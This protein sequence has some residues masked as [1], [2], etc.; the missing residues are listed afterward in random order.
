MSKK[1]FIILFLFVFSS[2]C[3]ADIIDN[4][5]NTAFLTP[6]LNSSVSANG[7]GTV[8]M[9]KTASAESYINWR[10]TSSYYIKL[11]NYNDR[12]EVTPS[13]SI[14]SGQYSLWIL[15]FDSAKQLL[16]EFQ[17]ASPTSD[18]SIQILKSVTTLAAQNNITNAEW[19]YIRFRL[20]GDTGS[21]FI[22]DKIHVKQGPG[23]WKPTALTQAA[24]KTVF[25]HEMTS[26]RTPGYSGWWDGW[27]YGYK[28]GEDQYYHSPWVLDASGKPDI[29][30]V[31]YPSV[32]CYDMKDP[33]LVE[34]HCQIMKMAGIGGAIFDLGFYSMDMDNVSMIT[35]YLSIMAQYGLKSV[36]CFEDKFHW[37]WDPSATTRT[38]AV[39]RTY[40]DMNNWLALFQN[41]GTQFYV[42]GTRPLFLTFSYEDNPDD[43]P[44]RGP[45]CL[46]PD[47]ITTWLNTFAPENK[48]VMLRQWFK[49]NEH[50]AVINGQYDWPKLFSDVPPQWDPPYKGY[51]DMADNNDEMYNDRELG[52]YWFKNNLADF[53]MSGVWP[54][55]DDL[56]IWGWSTVPH[57]MPRYDGLLYDA[58]WDWAIDNN[59]PL[60][61][62]A[63]WNDWFEGTIIEPSVEFG[64]L[65]IEKTFTKI[66]SFKNLSASPMPNFN[67]PIWIYKIRNITTHPYVTS[68]LDA[69]C[70]FIKQGQYDNAEQIVSYWANFFNIDSVTYWTVNTSLPAYLPGDYSHDNKINFKDLVHIGQCWQNG[71]GIKD[72]AV[73]ADNW[74]DE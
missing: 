52:Q 4:L 62:V 8:S 5:D 18:T 13:A 74:L 70:Q 22:F 34:Y 66:A 42:T 17:W 9:T 38:I 30:S 73:L 32:G 26:F 3:R 28:I 68:D 7:N 10:G 25:V 44:D 55:F 67:V 51:C 54:G 11:R 24:P 29:A 69:A 50:V 57:L 14:A 1:L 41:S 21:G 31:Y 36:I 2:C 35:N 63:T 48:P 59:L 45:Y 15:Y 23:Y 47:E 71:C 6:V 72:L 43:N 40:S 20:H 37:R 64:N 46:L 56:E 33:C 19:F 27:N 12:V 39:A 58:A 16:G 49:D 53:Y 60:V 65:Y 61:Q